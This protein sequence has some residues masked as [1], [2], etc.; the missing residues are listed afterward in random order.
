[1][2]GISELRLGRSL[3]SRAKRLR[4]RKLKPRFNGKFLKSDFRA[5][6]RV[7]RAKQPYLGSDVN[8]AELLG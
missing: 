2:R 7:P 4:V 8:L 3:Q 5:A 6:P 1:M